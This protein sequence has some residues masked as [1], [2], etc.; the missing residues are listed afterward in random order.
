MIKKWGFWKSYTI[1]G[2]FGLAYTAAVRPFIISPLLGH[3]VHYDFLDLSGRG[4]GGF[5]AG[6]TMFGIIWYFKRRN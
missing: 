1:G 6:G 2:L 4:L 3:Q 5:L